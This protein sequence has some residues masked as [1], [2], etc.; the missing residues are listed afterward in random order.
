MKLAG[1]FIVSSLE[2]AKHWVVQ[3]DCEPIA[4]VAPAPLGTFAEAA[5]WARGYKQA[6]WDAQNADSSNAPK[7]AEGGNEHGTGS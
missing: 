6:I 1:I 2:V 5:A 7:G 4:D 3:L